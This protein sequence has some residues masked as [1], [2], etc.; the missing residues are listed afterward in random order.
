MLGFKPKNVS[1]NWVHTIMAL[2]IAGYLGCSQKA[3]DL[4]RVTGRVTLDG[5]PVQGVF[6]LF[7]PEGRKA[8]YS[9]L[10]AE[11]KFVLQYNVAHS[12]AVVGNQKIQLKT[13]AEDELTELPAGVT[14]PTEVPPKYLAPFQTVEVKTGRNDFTFDLTSD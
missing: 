11:G 6:I 12:G 2:S 7:Q 8:S 14:Q 13:P 3:G 1:S 5:K 4:G 10:D 9:W